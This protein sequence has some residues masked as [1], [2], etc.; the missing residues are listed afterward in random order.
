MQLPV[1]FRSANMMHKYQEYIERIL[2][3]M[4]KKDD[5]VFLDEKEITRFVE[6]IGN[7]FAVDFENSEKVQYTSKHVYKICALEPRCT[8]CLLNKYCAYYKKSE[9]EKH[10]H[11]TLL[12][13][14]L[15]AGAGGFSLGFSQAGFYPVFAIDNQPC[16]VETYQH[17][18]PE[19]PGAN[20]VCKDIEDAN[21]EIERLSEMKNVAVII[22]GPPCQGF[23]TA[24]RQRM[25]DDPRNELYKHFV[26]AIEKIQPEFFV[27][28]NVYGILRIAKEISEDFSA[29]S[30]PYS[31][32]HMIVDA[33]NFGIPQNRRRVFFI[34]TR[35]DVN[36]KGVI[37]DITRKAT[38]Y[39][40]TVLQDAL[41]GL[42][43]LSAETR[44]NTTAQNSETSGCI[45]D[46][47]F[48]TQNSPY[49]QLI[50]NNRTIPLFFN[51]KARYNNKRDIEIFTKLNPGDLS[52]DP[53]IADI[54]PYANRNGI[55]RDKYYRLYP[56][57]P[58]KTITAHMKYDG[59]MYIHPNQARGLTPREAA[60]I[61]SYPDDYFFC[62]PYTKTYMQIGNSVPPLVAKTIAEVIRKYL[63]V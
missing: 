30:I 62:G 63:V 15:F 16:C 4:Y 58:C 32:G 13:A 36:I 51:H 46:L 54:M 9:V 6:R 19:V 39:P 42:K 34:G 14:D 5:P 38:Q 50:N 53:K 12:F 60:R 35:M 24:N 23:S 61:Q 33:V 44:I 57:K 31:V 25:I 21:E 47:S 45:I 55:F 11:D 27:M 43:P 7:D 10:R 40:F 48:S 26:K 17:N 20:I 8:C 2:E 52:D 56:D 18:H 29:L 1:L 3:L 49:L 59:N 41:E 37:A 22:G 28:E